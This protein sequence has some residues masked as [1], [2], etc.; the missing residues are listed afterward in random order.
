V[1]WSR[2]FPGLVLRSCGDAADAFECHNGTGRN[3][4]Q[5]G[6]AYLCFSCGPDGGVYHP[7]ANRAA[8]HLADGYEGHLTTFD[9]VRA[10]AG[11]LDRHH[12]RFEL[13]EHQVG[14][15]SRSRAITHSHTDGDDVHCHPDAGWASF[16][17]TDA[18]RKAYHFAESGPKVVP[19]SSA[20]KGEQLPYVAPTDEERV[21]RVVGDYRYLNPS[22]GHGKPGKPDEEWSR[23]AFRRTMDLYVEAARLRLYGHEPVLVGPGAVTLAAAR[24]ATTFRLTPVYEIRGWKPTPW[25]GLP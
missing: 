17:V 6:D 14:L 13:H 23:A 8:E 16:T 10:I 24:M 1:S 3:L 21:F 15:A 2:S 12:N 7:E 20:P 9:E 18:Q 11:E 25:L 22:A 19:T 4:R 5:A